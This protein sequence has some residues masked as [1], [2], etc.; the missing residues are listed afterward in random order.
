MPLTPQQKTAADAIASNEPVTVEAVAGS[1]KTTTIVAG[2]GK[3][4]GTRRVLACAFNVAI[5]KTLEQRVPGYVHCKT[6]NGIGHSMWQRHLG[7]GLTLD[8][9]KPIKQ[10]KAM[11][12][13]RQLPTS[14][15]F[16]NILGLFR[17]ARTAGMR[18]DGWHNGRSLVP[19]D[20]DTWEELAFQYDLD[21][22]EPDIE[23]VRDLFC[24][25]NKLALQGTIDFDDQIYQPVL[26]GAKSY[27][28]DQ[29][30][31][32]ESQDLNPLQHALLSQF[33][34]ATYQVVG[35][36]RQS[37]YGF[38]GA[39]SNSMDALAER[40]GLTSLPL[41]VCFR[42]G[43]SIVSEAQRYAPEIEAFEQSGLGEVESLQKWDLA[44]IPNGAAIL[45][46]YNAPLI[47]LAMAMIRARRRPDFQGRDIGKGM[48]ALVRKLDK[49]LTQRMETFGSNL[50]EWTDQQIG[51][52]LERGQDSKADAIRDK[53][54]SLLA[55]MEEPG[56]RTTTDL[57]AHID[58]F[59]SRSV[60]G[61][62][63]SSIHRAKGLEW[64]HVM[65]LDPTSSPGRYAYKAA[66]D[67]NP[68]PLR[69]ETNLKYVATTRAMAKLSYLTPPEESEE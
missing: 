1:G 5:K 51:M 57:A 42:C 44:S 25:S 29:I 19:D 4:P 24:R 22:N 58:Q 53:S 32:D 47:K 38:R 61:T 23:R 66:R 12:T 67:G 13:E 43:S 31:V 46:R 35:D 10:L 7:R 45:S 36:P 64:Q 62:V 15:S 40:F 50:S 59:F 60:G 20:R 52:A 28:Y 63:L 34:R 6:L 69:Q 65:W 21:A 16:A 33:M 27:D 54:D 3:V 9:D 8:A 17:A 30:V 18:P 26:Y 48:R 68:E 11:A 37:I 2:L 41:T 39:V 14:E 49:G 55:L 56:L